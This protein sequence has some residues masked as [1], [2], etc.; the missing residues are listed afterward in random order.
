MIPSCP[1]SHPLGCALGGTFAESAERRC[2]KT[3]TCEQIKL[4]DFLGFF[5]GLD[6][7]RKLRHVADHER[8]AVALDEPRARQFAELPCNGLPVGRD[9]ARYIGVSGR[10]IDSRNVTDN[11][12]VATESQ[13]FGLNAIAHRQ[14]RELIDP[15][16][17]RA[18]EPHESA[19]RGCGDLGMI[20]QE[21]G[22][23]V[24]P[25]ARRCSW[26]ERDDI[27]RARR[28]IEGGELPEHAARTEIAERHV[29]PVRRV[30][31]HP[32]A[33]G[34]D[35]MNLARFVLLADD[36]LFG[37]ISAPRTT[38]RDLGDH[39][40]IEALEDFDPPESVKALGD[41]RVLPRNWI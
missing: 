9:S 15:V 41:D 20:A 3:H 17:E 1:L 19:H 25:E 24:P 32:H 10:R 40:G 38:L 4:A 29:T 14:C 2:A 12:A 8:R 5:D 21:L 35:E 23:L 37:V 7:A 28:S 33:A 13:Q 22:E 30:E 16:A 18:N 39:C 34:K 26:N 31:V 6:K 11:R 27:G 36:L